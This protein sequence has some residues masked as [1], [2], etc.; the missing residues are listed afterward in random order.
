MTIER[1]IRI[2]AGF[3]VMVSLPLGVQASP[4]G[5]MLADQTDAEAAGPAGKSEQAAVVL[6]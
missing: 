6:E 3:F 2:L 4:L 5:K 1:Y